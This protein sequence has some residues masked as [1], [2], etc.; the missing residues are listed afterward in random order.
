M[1][2]KQA[3]IVGFLKHGTVKHTDRRIAEVI[4]DLFPSL[5]PK[6]LR[7][8]QIAGDDL[9]YQAQNELEEWNP[10]YKK[11]GLHKRYELDWGLITE[12]STLL[13]SLDSH[14]TIDI[15]TREHSI[16]LESIYEQIKDNLYSEN[17]SWEETLSEAY[18]E[19]G[20]DFNP[21][22]EIVKEFKLNF[23]Q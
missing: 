20:W 21:D 6:K 2:L 1:N 16:L 3:M 14:S 15:S 17:F 10:Q 11:W 13:S 19:I 22:K 9:V 18:K 7:G 23:K 5:C 12:I 8:N 4:S